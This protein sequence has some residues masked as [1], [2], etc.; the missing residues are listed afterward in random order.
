MGVN[1]PIRLSYSQRLRRSPSAVAFASVL[2]TVAG[3]AEFTLGG[4]TIVI[5]SYMAFAA[6]LYATIAS[7]GASISR[8]ISSSVK[9]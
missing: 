9:P 7:L 5:P 8:S 3:A 6:L 2:W 4:T 1:R